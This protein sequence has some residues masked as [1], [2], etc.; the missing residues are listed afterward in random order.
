MVDN[1]NAQGFHPE[2]SN[3]HEN[4]LPPRSWKNC[5]EKDNSH[6]GLHTQREAV[7][8]NAGRGAV[9]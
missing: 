6:Q 1:H 2:K 4:S 3:F 7:C 8:Q 9:S 5:R